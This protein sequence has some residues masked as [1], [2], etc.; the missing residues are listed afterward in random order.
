MFPRCRTFLR[1]RRDP[2]QLVLVERSRCRGAA[3]GEDTLGLAP[4]FRKG[5]VAEKTVEQCRWDSGKWDALCLEVTDCRGPD[6]LDVVERERPRFRER[7]IGDERKSEFMCG[8][9]E[10]AAEHSWIPLRV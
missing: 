10:R 2:D 5:S 6:P 9:S 4:I 7:R 8:V 1:S 3:R